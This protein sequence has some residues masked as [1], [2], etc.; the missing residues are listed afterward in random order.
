MQSVL[1]RGGG[2]FDA[3]QPGIRHIQ[4][5]IRQGSPL[6]L[7]LLGG[8]QL[9]GLLRWQDQDYLAIS[10]EGQPLTLVNRHAIAMLRA[11]A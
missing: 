11:L 7:T 3:S 2:G 5:L 8:E 9:Q 4:G 1:G 10:Q 6:K